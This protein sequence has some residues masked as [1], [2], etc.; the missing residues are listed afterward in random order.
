VWA[1]RWRLTQPATTGDR[2]SLARPGHKQGAFRVGG[3]E[4]HRPRAR[5]RAFGRRGPRQRGVQPFRRTGNSIGFPSF[6][7]GLPGG[8]W[9]KRVEGRKP[10]G[11]GRRGSRSISP[12]EWPGAAGNALAA[13]VGPRDSSVSAC[14]TPSGSGRCAARRCRVRVVPRG[15]RARRRIHRGRGANGGG[16]PATIRRG[17]GRRRFRHDAARRPKPGKSKPR[18]RRRVTQL[19][20]QGPVRSLD[21][22]LVAVRTEGAVQETRID[23]LKNRERGRRLL[24]RSTFDVT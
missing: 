18:G 17:G 23:S 13:A 19:G 16:L 4:R 2:R 3:R 6:P 10:N 11:S 1:R 22:C 24:G 12:T 14:D 7:P 21:V 15:H 8:D 9:R 20:R 5:R